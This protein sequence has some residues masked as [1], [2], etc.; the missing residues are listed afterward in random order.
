MSCCMRPIE[1]RRLDDEPSGMYGKWIGMMI[2]KRES[3]A[4]MRQVHRLR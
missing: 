4:K 2:I 3:A 1:D